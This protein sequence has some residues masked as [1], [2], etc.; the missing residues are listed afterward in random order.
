[1]STL[2]AVPRHTK[3]KHPGPTP[4]V[5]QN[6]PPRRK[7]RSRYNNYCLNDKSSRMKTT[8]CVVRLHVVSDVAR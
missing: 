8:F 7:Q 2:T 1:M 3:Y 4:N 6:N 5:L